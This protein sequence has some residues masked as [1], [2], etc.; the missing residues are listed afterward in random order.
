M[1]KKEKFEVTVAAFEALLSKNKLWEAY[2][3]NHNSH[4]PGRNKEQIYTDWKEWASSIPPYLWCS[5]AFA[6]DYTEQ[7]YRIWMDFSY[8]WLLWICSNLNK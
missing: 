1:T 5:S 6:W 4:I 7:G 2:L 8:E 3:T